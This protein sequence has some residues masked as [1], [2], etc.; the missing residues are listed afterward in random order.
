MQRIPRQLRSKLRRARERK[1][2]SVKHGKAVCINR[3]FVMAPALSS[4][5]K[6]WYVIFRV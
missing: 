5:V 3:A 4:T 1:E 2:D 6:K